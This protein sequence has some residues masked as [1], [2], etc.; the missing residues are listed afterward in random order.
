MRD[1]P[2]TLTRLTEDEV[3]TL[4]SG[5]VK[6]IGSKSGLLKI[7]IRD[8]IPCN[9][10]NAEESKTSLKKKDEKGLSTHDII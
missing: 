1:R 3:P 9:K 10:G 7:A 4:S 2:E 6:L 8:S 5:V